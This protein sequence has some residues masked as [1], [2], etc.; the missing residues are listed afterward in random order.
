[1]RY[2]SSGTHMRFECEEVDL[3]KRSVVSVFD[4]E[5]VLA[6]RGN[7]VSHIPAK[8]EVLETRGRDLLSAPDGQLMKGCLRTC[9][10][11]HIGMQPREECGPRGKVGGTR[12]C[13]HASVLY[14][15]RTRAITYGVLAANLNMGNFHQIVRRQELGLAG[16]STSPFRTSTRAAI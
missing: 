12:A 7:A 6:A 13:C 14:E 2:T 10:S 11:T 15:E 9:E 4:G 3:A 8:V 16:K 5:P 1:M